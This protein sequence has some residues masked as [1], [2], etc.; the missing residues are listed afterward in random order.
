M[1]MMVWVKVCVQMRL[2]MSVDVGVGVGVG[3]GSSVG[4]DIFK[5]NVKDVLM[6]LICLVFL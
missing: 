3:E 1:K 4:K 2:G 6:T 5:K